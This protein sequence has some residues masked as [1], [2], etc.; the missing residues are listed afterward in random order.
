MQGRLIWFFRSGAAL[1]ALVT[2][3]FL[4]LALA[5]VLAGVSNLSQ[6]GKYGWIFAPVGLWFL[7]SGLCG[8]VG[9]AGFAMCAL[10]PMRAF[11]GRPW[12]KRAAA[13]ALL[14]GVCGAL[15]LVLPSIAITPRSFGQFESLLIG[16]VV[17]GCLLAHSVTANHSIERTG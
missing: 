15:I 9:F 14:C 3:C 6:G 17:L 4:P 10:L 16:L 7:S 13:C 11:T 2:A 1:G 12:L 8:V 5:G